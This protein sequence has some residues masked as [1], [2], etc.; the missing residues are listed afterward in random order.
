[1]LRVSLLLG[2]VYLISESRNGGNGSSEIEGKAARVGASECG[3]RASFN[4]DSK[5]SNQESRNAGK[6]IVDGR[7]LKVERL[8]AE[9]NRFFRPAV[10][11][12]CH[13]RY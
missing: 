5:K 10:C 8:T 1:V 2:L 6:E 4:P 7:L 12:V 13:A 9:E 11:K 3:Q